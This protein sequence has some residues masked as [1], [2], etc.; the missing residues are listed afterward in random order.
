MIT[1]SSWREGQEI[2]RRVLGPP[3]KV[4]TTK[5]LV[6]NQDK[7]NVEERTLT[8]GARQMLKDLQIHKNLG[9]IFLSQK[10]ILFLVECGV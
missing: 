3:Q 5:L 4:S 6:V 2:I 1:P 8:V 9:K 10:Y 7:I